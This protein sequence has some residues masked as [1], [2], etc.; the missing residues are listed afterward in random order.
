MAEWDDL[1]N[2][3]E[4]VFSTETQF[5][6]DKWSDIDNAVL[7]FTNVNWDAEY[8]SVVD[9]KTD[10]ARDL[11]FDTLQNKYTIDSGWN[12]KQLEQFNVRAGKHMG[13]IRVAE[14]Y[15]SMIK[16]NYVKIELFRQPVNS[17]GTRREIFYYF[18]SPTISKIAPNTTELILELDSWTTFKNSLNIS[19]L[20]L[21]RGHYP[22]AL[23]PTDVYLE[24]PLDN[25]YGLTT[26]EPDLP[27]VKPLISNEKLISFQKNSPRVCIA[28]TADLSDTDSFWLNVSDIKNVKQDQNKSMPPSD[29]WNSRLGGDNDKSYLGHNG[30][31]PIAA[32]GNNQNNNGV[33]SLRVY[34]MAPA[35]FDVFINFLRFR[36]PQVLKTIQGVFLLDSELISEGTEIDF[37]TYKLKP[38]V[39]QNSYKII[40]TF[41]PSKEDFDY[42]DKYKDFA[43]LYTTQFAV[44]EVSNLQGKTVEISVEDISEGLEFYSRSSAAFPFLKLEAFINGIGGSDKRTY[45]VKPWNNMNA[46]L[47]KSSWED[48]NFDIN[49]PVYGV[50]A[51]ATEI[52]GM[53]VNAAIYDSINSANTIFKNTKELI[54]ARE[55]NRNDDIDKIFN[56]KKD[57]IANT[58]TNTIAEINK[59]Y[60]NRLN[61]INMDKDNST[62]RVNKNFNN[63]SD[64][65]ENVYT[66][67]I[68][69]INKEF[70]NV[71]D[72]IFRIRANT[73]ALNN[74][75]FDNAGD[76][77]TINDRNTN[78][79]F[80][81]RKNELGAIEWKAQQDL[82][83]LSRVSNRKNN[84]TID[85]FAEV[86]DNSI[87]T[88]NLIMEYDTV[89]YNTTQ[90]ISK[91]TAY[92]N[93]RQGALSAELSYATSTMN[94]VGNTVSSVLSLSPSSFV[95][96][97]TTNTV[98]K[99]EA[100]NLLYINSE[101]LKD[102]HNLLNAGTTFIEPPMM[103]GSEYATRTGTP[104]TTSV[105]VQGQNFSYTGYSKTYTEL[106]A[107]EKTRLANNSRSL[108]SLQ[109]SL[110]RENEFRSIDSSE[111]MYLIQDT[112]LG[113][114]E[115]STLTSE[116]IIADRTKAI[117]LA[118]NATTYNIA[119]NIQG[120]TN[121]N[122]DNQYDTSAGV[123]DRNKTVD[124]AI[125][126][127]IRT[128]DIGINNRT[129]TSDLA[130]VD[131]TYTVSST[132]NSRIKTVDSAIAE[133]NKNVDNAIN[134]RTQSVDKAINEYI[135]DKERLVNTR[136]YNTKQLNASAELYNAVIDEPTMYS[137]NSGNAWIDSWGLRGLDIRVRRCSRATEERAGRVFYRYGYTT[138]NM[139]IDEPEFSVMKHFSYWQASDLW[140]NG[141][142]VSETNKIIIRNI[143]L[144]GTTIW[145]D[146]NNVNNGSLILDNKIEQ[147]VING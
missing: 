4:Q 128:T 67:T 133:R 111:N 86:E 75:N 69:M 104:F 96:G 135:S 114:H 117:G 92:I 57:N 32:V 15:E 56:N 127:R 134:S 65:I 98:E 7:T 79:T 119:A 55:K 139:W 14:P 26:L 73:R 83:F 61:N 23:T 109:K 52:N 89:L 84:E 138:S 105:N 97:L 9:W 19:G 46:E 35:T 24:N 12:F 8:K 62:I 82:V 20:N 70:D 115:K 113:L 31:A 34:S 143:F 37:F 140:I 38:V 121:D 45:A 68:S 49:I 17:E 125:A 112:V 44:M 118:N 2:L 147:G 77:K 3:E 116:T 63:R 33:P 99:V 90:A 47:F 136:D 108:Y 141:A 85:Y 103:L 10:E 60:D 42:S 28:T 40:D 5:D 132:I 54:D 122:A 107:T 129:R 59:E 94:V 101:T 58:Y 123:N 71:S 146:P 120:V 145:N 66:N 51:E 6:Y 126:S 102:A 78:L 27:S 144:R 106:E 11:Y 13:V 1:S 39:Q 25:N 131:N 87:T 50:F 91:M 72:E 16:F 76:E 21:T 53:K 124:S 93:L 74:M 130:V 88:E 80:D 43:K 81:N 137:E 95:S 41:K 110:E 48:F 142:S 18:I 36:I 100:E 64:E 29:W 22:T 30:S